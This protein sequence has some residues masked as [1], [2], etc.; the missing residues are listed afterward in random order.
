[1]PIPHLFLALGVMA[2]WG[3]NFVTMRWVLDEVAPLTFA[4]VRFLLVSLPLLLFIPR[5]S[6]P[7]KMLIGYGLTAFSMQFGFIFLAVWLGMPVGLASLV[8]Q[9]QVFFTLLLALFVDQ[10]RPTTGQVLGVSIG[11]A[12]IAWV[13]FDLGQSMPLLAFTATLFAA[14]GW[15]IGNTLIKSMGPVSAFPLVIWASLVSALS[16][17]PLSFLLE[18]IDPWLRTADLV[19]Q[20]NAVFI[21]S[22]LLNAIGASILGYGGWAWLLRRHPA[23]IVAPFTLLVPVFGMGSAALLLNEAI[24]PAAWPGIVLVFLG[25]GLTQIRRMRRN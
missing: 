4:S 8:V 18:G 22:L 20:G 16:L 13:G 9:S 2:L 12:G 17:A 19:I 3:T 11:A 6:I 10:V 14:L 21:G 24:R 1:M 25:L 23:P 5:P 15:S 7:L